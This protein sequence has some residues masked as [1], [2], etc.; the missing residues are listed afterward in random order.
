[1]MCTSLALSS[2]VCNLHHSIL[3]FNALHGIAVMK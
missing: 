1:M 3:A 2:P